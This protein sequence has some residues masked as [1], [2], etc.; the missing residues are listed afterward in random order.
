MQCTRSFGVA[1]PFCDNTA[2][3]IG[4]SIDLL[5][6]LEHGEHPQRD[7]QYV[8]A[9]RPGGRADPARPYERTHDLRD[10]AGRRAE[11][12]G[13]ICALEAVGRAVEQHQGANRKVC[14]L[15]DFESHG[16]RLAD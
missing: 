9:G 10:E 16:T 13:Q 6:H 7:E 5:D 4:R 8:T 3:R 2:A 15:G 12:I 14:A 1:A 11:F